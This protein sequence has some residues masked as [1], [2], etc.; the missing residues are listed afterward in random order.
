MPAAKTRLQKGAR[1]AN[2]L[3]ASDTT[4]DRVLTL[5]EIAA[6]LRIPENAIFKLVGE[7]G[8]PGR[9][10]GREWRFLRSAVDEWLRTPMNKSSKEALLAMAGK[11][12]DDPHLNEMLAQ[13]YEQR[14]RPMLESDE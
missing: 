13:I 7:Q 11:W 5:S 3:P 1:R 8:L 14:G 12:K 6:Y 9:Q 4:G 10:I 2:K